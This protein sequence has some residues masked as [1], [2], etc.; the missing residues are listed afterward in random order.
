MDS[1]DVRLSQVMT[2]GFNN[3]V[4]VVLQVLIAIQP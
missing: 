4:A 3:W 2:G 1:R